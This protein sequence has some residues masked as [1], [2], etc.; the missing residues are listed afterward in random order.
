MKCIAA[1]TSARRELRLLR[2]D[3]K[4]VDVEFFGCSIRFNNRDSV[5]QAAHDVTERLQQ[6]E[7]PPPR[8][9]RRF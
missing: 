4:P 2:L 5:M 6:M 8:P 1:C 7:S 3:R 9:A